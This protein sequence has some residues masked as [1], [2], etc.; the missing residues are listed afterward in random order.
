MANS[1]YLDTVNRV[2]KRAGQKTIADANTFNGVSG[3]LTKAQ[4]QAQVYVD[5]A[6]RMCALEMPGHFLKRKATISTTATLSDNN[7][8]FALNSATSLEN[9]I[10]DSWFITTTGY[11]REL[12]PMSYEDWV[13]LDPDGH[14]LQSIPS[15]YIPWVPSGSGVADR[16]HFYPAPNAVFTVQYE[17]YLDPAVLSAATD[18]IV[19]PKKFEHLLWTTAG[20]FLEIVLAEGK[21]GDFGQFL[22]PALTTVRQ[23][24]Q[25]L[26]QLT[27]SVDLGIKMKPFRRGGTRT[28][29]SP[30]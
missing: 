15:H 1:T 12:K 30:D 13:R 11:G 6:N 26:S 4:V 28:A 21:A 17:Y 3:T 27:P 8:G 9:L 7:T 23:H 19:W 18:E 10:E 29:L 20:V 22:L 2:L 16:V 14:T 5:E 24:S 25:G